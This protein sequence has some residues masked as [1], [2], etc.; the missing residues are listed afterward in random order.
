MAGAISGQEYGMITL[1]E[2]K[3][4]GLEVKK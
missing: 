2:A 3:Q 1:E 4:K